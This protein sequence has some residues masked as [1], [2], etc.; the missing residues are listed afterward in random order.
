MQYVIAWIVVLAA[1]LGG[2]IGVYVLTR[3][4]PTLLPR[5]LVRSLITTWMLIP[6]P[7]PHYDS[8]YAPAFVVMLFEW[9]LQTDG[10]PGVA[11]RILL[12]ATVAVVALVSLAHGLK[13]Y[14]SRRS[15]AHDI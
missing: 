12:A 13:S 3:S 2:L 9:L 4:I 14:R 7:V 5:T 6:A 10:D 15:D 8:Q 11:I 1:G